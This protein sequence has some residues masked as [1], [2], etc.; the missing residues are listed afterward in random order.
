ML[1]RA[2]PAGTAPMANSLG[3]R[4]FIRLAGERSNKRRLQFGARDQ[5]SAYVSWCWTGSRAKCRRLRARGF[6]KL[7]AFGNPSDVRL[8][9]LEDVELA[10]IVLAAMLL[11]MFTPVVA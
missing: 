4:V 1:D 11:D 5:A 9:A 3:C 6:I 8:A 7:G 2:A 10:A